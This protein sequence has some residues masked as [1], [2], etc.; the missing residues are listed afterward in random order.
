MVFIY[1]I[2]LEEEKWYVGKSTNPNIR[3]D[4]HFQGGGSYWT[5]KYKPIKIQEIIPNQTKY[6]EDKWTR[7]YMDRYGIENVRGGTWCQVVLDNETINHIKKSLHASNDRCYH[8][9]ES[10]HF[11]KECSKEIWCCDFCGKE[12]ETENETQTHENMECLYNSFPN[13]KFVKLINLRKDELNGSIGSV[14][15]YNNGRYMIKLKHR[16][17]SIKPEN[18]EIINNIPPS[19]GEYVGYTIDTIVNITKEVVSSL[20]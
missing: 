18:L 20:L 15:R 7:I 4:K 12:Y 16:M 5:K 2:K 10:G 3:T 13:G 8:C 11:A 6:D 17:I 1:V 19:L 9:G 14:I